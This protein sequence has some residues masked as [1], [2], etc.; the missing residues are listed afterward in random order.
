MHPW[1]EQFQNYA[2]EI[3]PKAAECGNRKLMKKKLEQS[4]W[5]DLGSSPNIYFYPK[6]GARCFSNLFMESYINWFWNKSVFFSTPIWNWNE[7]KRFA[8]DNHY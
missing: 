7:Q 5:I 8:I 3:C 6:F 4:P 2:I 1:V